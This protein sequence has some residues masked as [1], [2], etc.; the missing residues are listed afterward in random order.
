MPWVYQRLTKR[1][2]RV[3]PKGAGQQARGR[4]GRVTKLFSTFT[5]SGK[6]A[7]GLEQVR[8]GLAAPDAQAGRDVQRISAGWTHFGSE[9]PPQIAMS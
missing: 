1:R 9:A 8:V 5:P 3:D 4:P 7:E 2:I 6:A